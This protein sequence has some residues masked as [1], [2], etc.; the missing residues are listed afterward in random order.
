MPQSTLSP[1]PASKSILRLVRDGD[2][3]D[4]EPPTV[5][6]RGRE[7]FTMIPAA[8]RDLRDGYCLA[9]YE[10]IARHADHRTGEAFP[11]IATI[12]EHTGWSKR[13]IIRVLDRLEEAGVIVR[14]RRFKDGMKAGNLYRIPA[15]VRR[16]PTDT[17]LSPSGTLVGAPRHLGSAPQNHELEPVELHPKELQQPSREKSEANGHAPPMLLYRQTIGEETWAKVAAQF[18]RLDPSLSAAWFGQT[19][20]DAEVS[21]GNATRDQLK[22]AVTVTLSEIERRLKAE[23]TGAPPIGNVKAFTRSVFC[24]NLEAAKGVAV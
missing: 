1:V 17:T 2:D 15:N 22:E 4:P 18:K 23:A 6:V 7:A 11:S 12:C 5:P 16:C 14:E 8:V 13:T 24:R 21:Y 10:A 3:A 9:V 20:A 19:M